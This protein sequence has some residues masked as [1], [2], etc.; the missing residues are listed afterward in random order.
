MGYLL[1]SYI[2]WFYKRNNI[3][4]VQ[5]SHRRLAGK[6]PTCTWQTTDS[7]IF[8]KRIK[9]T[10]SQHSLFK[11]V[12]SI[13]GRLVQYS[14]F[15]LYMKIISLSPHSHLGYL[16]LQTQKH[17]HIHSF[18]I[19]VFHSQGWRPDIVS[20]VGLTLTLEMAPWNSGLN[21]TLHT[22]V[23]SL[24]WWS[25]VWRYWGRSTHWLSTCVCC[26]LWAV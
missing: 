4:T 11:H 16:L 10:M 1:I 26:L 6:M 17:T 9:D 20:R 19:H 25:L 13:R 18:I 15:C 7:G 12:E 21:S 5:T 14:M 24:Q 23:V 3:I 2:I 8:R 22:V